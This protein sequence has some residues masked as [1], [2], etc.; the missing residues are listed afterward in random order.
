VTINNIEISNSQED[1]LEAILVISEKNDLVRITDL[2]Q[3]MNIS[4]PS[5][6]EAVKSLVDLGL[7][8]HEKYGPVELTTEGKRRAAEV[9]KRHRLLKKFLIEVLEVPPAI[10]E[11]DACLMEHAI[12]PETSSRL[13]KFLESHLTL[14]END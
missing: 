1:Y 5:A 9:H 7:L 3:F 13:I 11:Q 8:R 12:S 10:A 6:S 2:A 14:D 4:K